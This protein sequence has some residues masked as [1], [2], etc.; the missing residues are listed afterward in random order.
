[1]SWIAAILSI[2]GVFLNAKK[3]ILCWPFWIASNVLWI[4]YSVATAQWAL[5][6]LW[7]VFLGTNIYGWRE[8]RKK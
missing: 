2:I 4:V 8:W 3:K 7:V 5:L 1:M 6:V